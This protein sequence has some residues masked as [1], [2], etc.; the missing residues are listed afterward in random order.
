MHTPLMENASFSEQLNCRLWLKREDLQVVRSYKLRGAYNKM[1]QLSPAERAGNVVCASAGNH[2][3]GVAFACYRLGISGKIFMPVTTPAQKIRKVELFGKDRVE[4][5]LVGDTF[6]Q[7]STAAHAACEASGSTFVHPFNDEQVMAGQATTA[8]EIFQD[9][10]EPIDY[11]FLPIGGGGLA[12]GVGSYMKQVSPHTRIIGV[13]PAGAASMWAAFQAKKVVKLDSID[14]FVDGA[15]VQQVGARTYEICQEVLHG[16]LQVPEGQVCATILQLYNEEAIV[17]E[18]AG[19]LTLAGLEQMKQEIAGK[20]V[21]CMVS[22]GNNDVLRMEEIKERALLHLGLKHYFLISFPQRA[23]ALRDF[24]SDVLGP[25]D[26]ITHF[27]Y[28]KKNNRE[29]GPALVAIELRHAKDYDALIRRMNE[30]KVKYRCVN[31]DPI[32]FGFLM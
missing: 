21:V 30:R 18:P 9:A 7:A 13:E 16:L 17:V 6:D 8:V 11:L 28:T 4:I 14:P 5:I 3:Q 2:A 23:G 20:N 19:A 26:D 1:A 25:T 31:D 12:A 22:G 15:A 27:E 32:L 29:I 24:L 10:R